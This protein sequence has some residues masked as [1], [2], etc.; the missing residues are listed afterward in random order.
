MK[1]TFI[2]KEVTKDKMN[3]LM[4]VAAEMSIRV[5]GND[6]D[7]AVAS[8]PNA[9]YNHKDTLAKTAF[10]AEAASQ[11]KLDLLLKIA[12]EM[13]IRLFPLS[14]EQMEDMLL[15]QGSVK[16]EWLAA[17]N[18]HWDEFLRTHKVT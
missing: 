12:G 13:G 18:E 2:F 7:N 10:L 14:D 15:A 17:E 16:E 6:E 8:E 4:Q 1:A 3:L 11:Q 5:V 9:S